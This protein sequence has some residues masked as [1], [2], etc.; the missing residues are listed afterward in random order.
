VSLV[1]FGCCAGLFAFAFGFGFDNFLPTS[2]VENFCGSGEPL[3]AVV[4]G[5]DEGAWG[6]GSAENIIL[7]LDFLKK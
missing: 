4:G 5:F 6:G 1:A 2:D 7:P 3:A